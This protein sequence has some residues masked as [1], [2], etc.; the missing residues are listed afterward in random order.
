MN[1][2]LEVLLD[3]LKA[4]L[5]GEKNVSVRKYIRAKVKCLQGGELPR[6]PRPVRSLWTL[7]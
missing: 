5:R 4:R 3:V 7:Y 2:G 1:E 6:S